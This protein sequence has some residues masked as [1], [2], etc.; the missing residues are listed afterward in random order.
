MMALAIAGSAV[1]ALAVARDVWVVWQSDGPRFLSGR[2]HR[3]IGNVA[4]Y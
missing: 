2:A 1:L 4:V 3:I